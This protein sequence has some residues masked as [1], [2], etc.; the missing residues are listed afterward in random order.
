VFNMI[1]TVVIAF[2]CL[3]LVQ[4]YIDLTLFN[5]MEK[6]VKTMQAYKVTFNFD[7]TFITWNLKINLFLLIIFLF[8]FAAVFLYYKIKQEEGC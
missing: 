8:L 3:I 6:I 2:F 7:H 1:I 5:A 4:I